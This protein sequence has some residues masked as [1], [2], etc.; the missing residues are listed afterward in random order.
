[1]KRPPTAL[2]T[3]GAL[4][5]TRGLALTGCASESE[6]TPPRKP[7]APPSARVSAASRTPVTR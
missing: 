2:S 7:T 1:M 4:L 3:G 6:S 5:L